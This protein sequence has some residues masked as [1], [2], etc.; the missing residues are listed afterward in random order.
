MCKITSGKAFNYPI[1]L[2]SFHEII[3]QKNQL[4]IFVNRPILNAANIY[5][6]ERT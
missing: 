2:T 5:L 6:L 4:G 1:T 3:L